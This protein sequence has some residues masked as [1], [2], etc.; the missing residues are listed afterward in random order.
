MIPIAGL[1]LFLANCLIWL[2]TLGST[3]NAATAET[4]VGVVSG[5]YDLSAIVGQASFSAL[6]AGLTA[7]V[8]AGAWLGETGSESWIGM[9]IKTGS[10]YA[11]LSTRAIIDG[12]GDAV[13][14]ASLGSAIKDTDFRDSF[15]ASLASFAVNQAATGLQFGVG[16]I[17]EFSDLADGGFG[18]ALLH[19]A[20]G[21]AANAALDASCGSGFVAGFGTE[22][23]AGQL[24]AG[25]AGDPGMDPE[26]HRSAA[27]AF[28]QQQAELIGAAFGYLTSGGNALNVNQGAAIARSAVANNRQ[29]HVQEA[30]LIALYADEYALE[31][32]I[33]REQAVAELTGETLRGVSDDFAHLDENETARAFLD[34][35][36]AAGTEVDGQTL[37]GQLDRRSDEYRNST[38]NRDVLYANHE[39]YSSLNFDTTNYLETGATLAYRGILNEDAQYLNRLSRGDMI[40]LFDNASA[41][42]NVWAAL[43]YENLFA[44]TDDDGLIQAVVHAN[45]QALSAGLARA[46]VTSDHFGFWEKYSGADDSLDAVYRANLENL[47]GSVGGLEGVLGVGMAR[48]AGVLNSQIATRL[49]ERV[50]N[51]FTDGQTL[52]VLDRKGEVVAITANDLVARQP[53]TLPNGAI[54]DNQGFVYVRNADGTSSSRLATSA[55]ISQ[56]GIQLDLVRISTANPGAN[57]PQSAT[58]RNSME[59]NAFQQVRANPQLGRNLGLNTDIRFVGFEKMHQSIPGTNG[60]NVAIHYQYNP[61]TGQVLDLK[62]V[63]PIRNAE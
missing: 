36:E 59:Q 7:G 45:E 55:E 62:V 63:S 40:A 30:E 33:T 13:L 37:F 15:K 44:E 60:R 18:A 29:L 26:A 34:A 43:G 61:S 9:P 50:V 47:L 41:M 56:S 53:R 32:G 10:D 16:E 4:T 5:E 24:S 31:R 11:A 27:M 22:L 23:I 21:C 42:R 3:A 57:P 1:R 39:L 14:T 17:K 48:S 38:I 6:S 51:R 35:L 2:L 25:F 49:S 54:I 46:T 12:V 8:D 28:E 52:R 20:I 58:P 19:G